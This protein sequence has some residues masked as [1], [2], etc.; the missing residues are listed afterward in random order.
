MGCHASRP[1]RKSD[2][3]D[4][5]PNQEPADMQWQEPRKVA[6]TVMEPYDSRPLLNSTEPN[7][8]SLNSGT[9]FVS[10]STAEQREPTV[11]TLPAFS[12]VNGGLMGPSSPPALESAQPSAKGPAYLNTLA[13]R[14]Y[15]CERDLINA[16]YIYIHPYL[17]LLPPPTF[18]QYE[19]CFA[20]V[21]PI[22]YEADQSILPFWPESPL[23]LAISAL[24]VLIPLPKDPDPQSESATIIRRSFAQLYVRS[25]EHALESNSD[26]HRNTH[27]SSYASTYTFHP[28]SLLHPNIFA[29]LEPILALL[30]LTVYDYCQSG[31]RK[32]MRSRAHQA[33]TAAMDLS[34]HALS[35]D[36]VDAQRR[37]WWMTMYLASQA[38]ITNHSAPI[39]L[40]HDVR[41]TTPYPEF[42]NRRETWELLMEA[43]N[44]LMRVGPIAKELSKKRNRTNLSRTTADDIRRL[45]STVLA[46]GAKLDTSSYSVENEGAEASAARNLWMISL[47]FVHTAR[48]K[49]HR[50]IAFGDSP[51]L[52]EKTSD[53]RTATLGNFSTTSPTPSQPWTLDVDSSFPFT[54]QESTDICLRSALVLSR[55]IRNLPPPKLHYS[56]GPSTSMIS[57][58]HTE[59]PVTSLTRSHAYPRSLP[60]LSC[61]TM[62]SC[63]VLSMLLR[64]LRSCLCTRDLSACYYLLRCAQ[65]G[66][67][68]QDAERAIEEMRNGIGALYAALKA[69]SV[70]EG[71][72]DMAKDV[73]S[74]YTAYFPGAGGSNISI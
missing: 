56:D 20:E 71:V 35:A 36:A 22:S 24:L 3:N 14:A 53:L 18:P 70:F 59:N 1:S 63:Y 66:T 60:Y 29:N 19:D 12:F 69:D 73:E 65:P 67:E 16:Y 49:L 38:S 46:L 33:L 5:P 15:R 55:T 42:C 68:I 26:H 37:A 17:P 2:G 30:V 51:L 50:F 45:D 10:L 43:Q 23:A 8:S 64:R 61:C 39:M 41:I 31:N 44:A 11:R 25:A 32:Q 27:I 40:I 62:Q 52:L 72:V 54:A 13:I 48:I 9:A 34:L 58:N 28:S 74:I 21:A 4:A 6:P 57:A 7:N 47:L